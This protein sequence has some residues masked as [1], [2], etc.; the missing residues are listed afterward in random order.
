MAQGRFIPDVLTRGAAIIKARGASSAASA[1][2]G[3]VDSVL[4]LTTPTAVGDTFSMCLCSTNGQLRDTGRPH[5]LLPCR[6]DGRTIAYRS[7]R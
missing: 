6:T 3:I 5:H 2:N 1:A 4:A 7:R